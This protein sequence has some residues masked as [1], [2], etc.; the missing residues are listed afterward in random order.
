MSETDKPQRKSVRKRQFPN[1]ESQLSEQFLIYKD[2][3]SSYITELTKLINKI[4]TCLENKHYSKLGD[5]DNLLE[6]VITKVCRVTTK[7]IDLVSKDL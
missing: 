1:E 6:S 3:R 4:K 5:Y 7:L 2:R